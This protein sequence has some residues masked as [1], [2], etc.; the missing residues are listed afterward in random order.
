MAL[1]IGQYDQRITFQ[2]L[3]E[4]VS[5]TAAV[6]Q[7]WSDLATCWA[8][9]M[10][11]DGQEFN[12]ANKLTQTHFWIVKTRYRNDITEKDR[13]DHDGKLLYISSISHDSSR[14]EATEFLCT[15][16]PG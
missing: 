9:C 14:S 7:S 8:F 12:E 2:R 6:S 15:E 1:R 13:I 16:Y 11:K 4:T 3:T 10:S 5:D